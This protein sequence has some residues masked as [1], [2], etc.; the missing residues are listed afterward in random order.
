MTLTLPVNFPL[1]LTLPQRD[2]LAQR[3]NAFD[4]ATIAQR[5]IPK[6]GAAPSDRLNRILDG[7][8]A[9]INQAENPQLFKLVDELNDAV[10]KEKLGDLADSILNAKP[11]LGSRLRGLLDRKQLQKALDRA[12]EELGRVARL[13]S[14]T[15]SEHVNAME[16]KLQTE[17]ARL[18]EELRVLDAQKIEYRE[19][20]VAHSIETAFLVNALKKARDAAP[21]LLAA[22]GNDIAQ[23]QE[24]QD[25]LQA[26]ESVAL[27]REA[28]MTKLPSEQLVIRQ[29]QSAGIS[30]LQEVLVTMSDRFAGIRMTLL[31]IHGAQLVQNVQRL[32]QSGANLDSGLQAVRAK[33]MQTTVSSAANAPGDNRVQQ[34]DNLKRVVADT[35]TLQAI[36]EKARTDNTMKFE[37]ARTT[38]AQVRE[39]L[40]L[41]LGTA[42]QPGRSVDGHL[43]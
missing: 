42:I 16:R 32:A 18:S 28:M 14:K 2:D 12:Y 41:A 39:D 9:R 4:F 36:V 7:F 27:S 20:F 37:V 19:A 33:L 11:S 13:K 3:V 22:A 26:L 43:D 35:A 10:A 40:L 21:R 17:M 1:V 15:L 38:M 6:L 31:T 25:K 30:T 24:V 29:L 34:A 8:L 23:Q 5:D